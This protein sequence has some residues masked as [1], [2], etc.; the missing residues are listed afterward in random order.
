MAVI[1]VVVIFAV[2]IRAQHN[3]Q[4]LLCQATEVIASL[5]PRGAKLVA[6]ILAWGSAT[7]P[8]L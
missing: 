2:V 7:A 8:V 4:L 5:L 3:L 6:G 1:I